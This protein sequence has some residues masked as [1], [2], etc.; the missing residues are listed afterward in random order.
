VGGG[1]I[2]EAWGKRRA[3]VAGGG[4]I[5]GLVVDGR[6]G[7]ER[8]DSSGRASREAREDAWWLGLGG[9]VGLVGA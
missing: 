6:Y 4:R 8:E 3:S 5:W 9:P 1:G 2:G 7:T